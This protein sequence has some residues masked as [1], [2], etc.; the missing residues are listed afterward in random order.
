[1]VIT[2]H[3]DQDV[4]ELELNFALY[5]TQLLKCSFEFDF[6]EFM[7]HSRERAERRNQDKR[8]NAVNLLFVAFF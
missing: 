2:T 5:L 6:N 1:M 8:I 3:I 7:N 4:P